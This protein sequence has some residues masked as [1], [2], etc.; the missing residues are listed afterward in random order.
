M[1]M[2]GGHPQGFGLT[3]GGDSGLISES[4]IA[5]RLGF[6]YPDVQTPKANGAGRP[7]RT[8]SNIL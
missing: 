6:F 1:G 3:R 4:I 7:G 5:S 8:L 2:V